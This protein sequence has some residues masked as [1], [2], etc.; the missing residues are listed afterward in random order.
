MSIFDLI[1]A[2]V[3]GLVVLAHIVLHKTIPTTQE[4]DVTRG[5]VYAAELSLIVL[6]IVCIIV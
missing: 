5:S 4:Y 3:L 6:A 2:I 1:G